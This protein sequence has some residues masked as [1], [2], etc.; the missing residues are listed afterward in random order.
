MGSIERMG[1]Y[2]ERETR[3]RRG[4][5]SNSSRFER[6]SRSIGQSSKQ[7]TKKEKKKKKKKNCNETATSSLALNSF[8]F[9]LAC[10]GTLSRV[11]NWSIH[12][13][14]TSVSC[15]RFV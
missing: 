13:G 14:Y 9:D 8:H 10:E 11:S 1:G 4:P 6:R 15:R 5:R 7:R 12:S 3:A 2:T